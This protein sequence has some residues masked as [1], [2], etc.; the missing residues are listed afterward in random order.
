MLSLFKVL[1]DYEKAKDTLR[2]F[3]SGSCYKNMNDAVLSL[4]DEVRQLEIKLKNYEEMKQGF[5][6]VTGL[7]FDEE[8]K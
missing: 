1:K 3:R 6:L 7:D 5:K 4:I 8:R 2:Q